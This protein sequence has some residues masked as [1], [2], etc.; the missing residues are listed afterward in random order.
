MKYTAK[1]C[2][3]AL[4]EAQENAKETEYDAVI[5]NLILALSKNS[6]LFL[7]QKISQEFYALCLKKQNKVLAEIITSEKMSDENLEKIAKNIKQNIKCEEVIIKNKI[8][9][10]ILGGAIIKIDDLLIDN[11]VV[12]RLRQLKANLVK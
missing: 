6:Q 2:G 7:M 12:G 8:D 5:K 4:Y 9:K 1:K 11:S 3:Q 10:N